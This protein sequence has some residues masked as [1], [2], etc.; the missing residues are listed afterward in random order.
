MSADAATTP[1]LPPGLL[2]EYLAGMR[3][4]L[5][6]LAGLAARLSAAGGDRA[7]LDTL[8]RETHKIRGSAGSYGFAEASRLAAGMEAT[9]RDW[10][11][12][13]D[14]DDVERGS[15]AQWFTGR[16]AEMLGLPVP[17]APAVARPTAAPTVAP[18][19]AA[20]SR[21]PQGP[22]PKPPIPPAAPAA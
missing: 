15:L 21:P 13:P 20:P 3:T 14:E 22:R 2:E 6:L 18:R 7:A 8:Q 16:L 19:V 1:E 11:T 12:R 17:R 9:V 5:T 4:T 10:A